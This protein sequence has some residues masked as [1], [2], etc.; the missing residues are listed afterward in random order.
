MITTTLG[1]MEENTL[2]KRE[3]VVDNEI[4]HTQWIEYWLDGECIHRSVDIKLK[5]GLQM[6]GETGGIGG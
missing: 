6:F 5:K 3:G 2:E 1:D 4:E